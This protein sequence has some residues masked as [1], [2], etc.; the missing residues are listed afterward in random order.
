MKSERLNIHDEDRSTEGGPPGWMAFVVILVS[1]M[2]IAAIAFA[3]Y[4]FTSSSPVV[5]EEP[6]NDPVS[7][8]QVPG[9]P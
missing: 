6:G 7:V 9:L 1:V 4:L 5:P 2:L 3:Y 8:G